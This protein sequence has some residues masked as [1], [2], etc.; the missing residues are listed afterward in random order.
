MVLE[1]ATFATFATL[2]DARSL[3]GGQAGMELGR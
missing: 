3:S 2:S 1:P